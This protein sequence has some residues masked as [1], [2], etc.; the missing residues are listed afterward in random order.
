MDAS[1]LC[2]STKLEHNHDGAAPSGL[3]AGAQ[4]LGQQVGVNVATKLIVDTMFKREQ[5]EGK[6][7]NALGS[8][9]VP[10]RGLETT[11]GNAPVSIEVPPVGLD[12]SSG[13]NGDDGNGLFDGL[14]SFF[15]SIVESSSA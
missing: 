8:N 12:T 15:M 3:A 7:S 6:G 14:I 11:L 2:V 10:P 1:T 4:A 5:N 9:E 13:V